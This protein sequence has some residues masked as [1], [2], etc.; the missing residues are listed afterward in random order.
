MMER[1]P[2]RITASGQ[3]GDFLKGLVGG[4]LF[5]TAVGVLM[6]PQ[7]YAV[8]RNLRRDVM[9]A[10]ADASHIATDK[11]Q[12]ATVRVGDAVEDLQQK[13]RDAYGSALNVVV[14]GAED[15]K[16]RATKAQIELDRRDAHAAHGSS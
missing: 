13:G 12:A 14:R 3:G 2:E 6:A 9:A 16:A 5:G 15:V 8:L 11:Y 1:Q 10:A 7:I 4:A